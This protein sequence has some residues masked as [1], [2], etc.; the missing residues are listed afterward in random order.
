MSNENP[1]EDKRNL[2]RLANAQVKALTAELIG[3]SDWT[4]LQIILQEIIATYVCKSQ[5]R[6]SYEKLIQLL[7]EEVELRYKENERVKNILLEGVP[8][9]LT[10][11]AA[12]LK[13]EGWE[14]AVWGHIKK[15]GLFTPEARASL[16]SALF[17]RG[18]DRSDTAA[19]LWLTMSGDYSDKLD[20]SSDDTISQF[21]EAQQAIFSKK[22]KDVSE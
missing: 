17:E 6:P 11:I 5:S 13:K 20:V 1:P 18:K 10:S 21:R 22:I 3:E 9:A 12:W 7:K 15:D 2:K 8:T 4:L 19:K 14:E 16:I